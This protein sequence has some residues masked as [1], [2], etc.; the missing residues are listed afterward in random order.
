[1]TR[2]HF[3]NDFL[4]LFCEKNSDGTRH[5]RLKGNEL[6]Q[7]IGTRIEASDMEKIAAFLKSHPEI[8]SVDLCYNNFGDAG[9][10]ILCEEYF[11]EEN[12]MQYI[13]IMNCDIHAEGMQ[14]FSSSK[15]LRLKSCR[16]NGNSIGAEGARYIARLI[17]SC[18]T[19][20][21][22]DIAQTDQTLESIESI[23]I[24]IEHSTLRALD[25]SRIIPLSYYTKYNSA[26]LADDLSVALKMNE[27]LVELHMQKCH[28]D[29]HD[30][31]TLLSGLKANKFVE[32][33]DLACNKIGDLGAEFIGKWLKQRPPLRAL[34]IASNVIRD[35]GARALSFGLPFSRVRFL[36]VT[37]NKIEDWGL[38]DLLDTLKKSCQMRILFLWGNQF[39]EMSCKRLFRMLKSGVLKQEYLD[40][41]IYEVDGQLHAAEYPSNHFKHRYYGAMDYGCRVDLKIIRNDIPHPLALPRELLNFVHMG[42]YPHV[43][44]SLGLL[45]KKEKKCEVKIY[46]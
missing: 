43:D 5:L 30:M 36:D 18:P 22:I 33:L 24:V 6:Y 9:L 16:I 42:R 13:N 14:K 41:K 40:V 27:T 44:K 1:M 19:L 4:K 37:N 2:R 15:F 8:N 45:E 7:R 39:G 46:A 32:F 23:L 12:N 10:E 31:E 11:N 21:N 38:T 34:N 29:G 3:H 20:E 17:Q 25:I 26:T 28:I 35:V